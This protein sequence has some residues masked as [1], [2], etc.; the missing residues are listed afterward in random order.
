MRIPQSFYS[1]TEKFS[2]ANTLGGFPWWLRQ[3]RIHSYC[4]RRGL[5]PWI[6]DIPGEENGYPLQYSYLEN[7]VDRGAWWVI[8]HEVTKNQT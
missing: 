4:G 8:V 6:G 7:P 1:E 3:K 2:R 5:D